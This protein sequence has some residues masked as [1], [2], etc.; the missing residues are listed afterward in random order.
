MPAVLLADE[1]HLGG[2]VQVVQASA[3]FQVGAVF[4]PGTQSVMSPVV[5]LTGHPAPGRGPEV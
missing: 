3:G 1:A 2:A 4:V 5:G